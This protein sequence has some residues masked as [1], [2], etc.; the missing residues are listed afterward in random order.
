MYVSIKYQLLI[1]LII[2]YLINI[3]FFFIIWIIGLNN[4]DQ[5]FIQTLSYM[6]SHDPEIKLM[7]IIWVILYIILNCYLIYLTFTHDIGVLENKQNEVHSNIVHCSKS[8]KQPIFIIS[9]IFYLPLTFLKLYGLFLLWMYD[10]EMDA[11]EHYVWTGIALISAICCSFFLMLRRFCSRIYLYL[12]KWVYLIFTLNMA[13]V[14]V[15]IVIIVLLALSDSEYKGTYELIESVFIGLD[16]VFQISD[17]YNDIIC[18]TR[19]RHEEIIKNKKNKYFKNNNEETIPL[20][21]ETDN[22]T[23]SVYTYKV[24]SQRKNT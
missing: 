13:F 22:N 5:G 6:I 20:K 19:N 2:L 10:V 21:T 3:I 16:P 15:Q 9:T 17:Y 7:Y 12:H 24:N 18:K 14:I 1:A 11:T 23:Y 8:V 4:N